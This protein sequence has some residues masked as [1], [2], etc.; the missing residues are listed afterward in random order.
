MLKKTR[1][2]RAPEE[3]KIAVE[4]NMEPAFWQLLDKYVVV[5]NDRMK[6]KGW[7]KVSKGR[8]VGGILSFFFLAHHQLIQKESDSVRLTEAQRRLLTVV[9]RDELEELAA[10]HGLS[11]PQVR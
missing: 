7:P 2:K 6:K 3:T 4:I 10:T 1:R 5:I 9:G 11:V 8:L